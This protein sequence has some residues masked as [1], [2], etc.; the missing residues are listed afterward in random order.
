[1]RLL[2]NFAFLF[3]CLLGYISATPLGAH[4]EGAA[5]AVSPPAVSTFSSMS[6]G[7]ITQTDRDRPRGVSVNPCYGTEGFTKIVDRS[8]R[9]EWSTPPPP[10][11]QPPMLK[12]NR[13]WRALKTKKYENCHFEFDKDSKTPGVFKCGGSGYTLVYDVVPDARRG[14]IIICG[15]DG[16]AWHVRAWAV[17]Y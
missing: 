1:M 7:V 12:G 10:V 9:R 4:D 11:T 5:R 16:G 15:D 14:D 6:T 2:I 8:V 13:D 3:I 17:E